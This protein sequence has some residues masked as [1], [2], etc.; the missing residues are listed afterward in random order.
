M[1]GMWPDS[2][3]RNSTRAVSIPDNATA[4]SAAPTGVARSYQPVA[5]STRKPGLR[6]I[7]VASA[8]AWLSGDGGCPFQNNWLI[9]RNSIAL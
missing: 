7:A 8:R 1:Y 2:Y 3:S 5:T 9:R 4:C 6:R